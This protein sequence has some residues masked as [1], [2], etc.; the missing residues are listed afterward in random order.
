MRVTCINPPRSTATSRRVR[1]ATTFSGTMLP[2]SRFQNV[3]RT[4]F[5]LIAT[6]EFE[7][8]INDS[9]SAVERHVPFLFATA[10]VHTTG[11]ARCCCSGRHVQAGECA[12]ARHWMLDP[13]RQSRG[14]TRKTASVLASRCVSNTRR[15]ASRRGA[16]RLSYRIIWQNV[17]DDHLGRELEIYPR[18]SHCRDWTASGSRR[19]EILGAVYGSRFHT[20]NDGTRTHTLRPGGLVRGRRRNMPGDLRWSNAN[21]PRRR[22]PRNRSHG[23]INAPHRYCLRTA[24]FDRD[25][26]PSVIAAPDHNGP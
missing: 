24:P 21:Q 9:T 22:L 23:I 15:G 1:S 26:P 14:S 7:F 19:R 20:R 12:N 13:G 3:G 2:P 17:V 8:Q 16:A 25:H 6:N 11:S 5:V 10:P 4:Q 18:K